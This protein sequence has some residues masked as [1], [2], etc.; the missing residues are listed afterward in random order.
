M[1]AFSFYVDPTNT[2]LALSLTVILARH[3]THDEVGHVLSGRSE[4]A[5]NGIGRD[6]AERLARRLS[7]ISIAKVYTSPRRRARETAKVIASR[8]D[9]EPI[10]VDALD[11]IDFG[12][13]AGQR[14][15]DLEADPRWQF[16][17]AAR[18]RA[19]TPGGET[20][21]IATARSLRHLGACDDLGVILCVSH[22]DVIR[23]LT[24]HYLGLDADHLLSFDI[25]PASI[26]TI[27]LYQGLVKIVA[28]NERVS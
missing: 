5:L 19:S 16:W 14:F 8:F 10:K 17:N 6:Q 26:T 7:R 18:G 4:I 12:E 23:G 25:D 22:C 3:G 13:W 24:A 11:E 9:L 15:A 27:Q 21:A 28:I 1:E 20:M 2:A